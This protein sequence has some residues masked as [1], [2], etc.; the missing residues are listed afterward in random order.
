MLMRAGVEA[1]GGVGVESLTVASFCGPNTRDLF[2][3]LCFR[4]ALIEMSQSP[5]ANVFWREWLYCLL[6]RVGFEFES[7]GEEWR[8]EWEMTCVQIWK[9]PIAGSKVE[10]YALF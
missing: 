7:V 6:P 4:S 9:V 10:E 1:E 5:P 3:N 8:R 2:A